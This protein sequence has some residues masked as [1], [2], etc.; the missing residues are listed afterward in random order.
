MTVCSMC[1]NIWIILSG[2]SLLIMGIRMNGSDTMQWFLG[3][4]RLSNYEICVNWISIWALDTPDL[5]ILSAEKKLLH[6]VGV[7]RLTEKSGSA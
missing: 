7:V 6:V 2:L 3:L 4:A 5:G 1:V